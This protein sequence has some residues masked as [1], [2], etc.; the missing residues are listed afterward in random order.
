MKQL[1]NLLYRMLGIEKY[2]FLISRTYL[3][4]INLGFFKNRYAEL[5]Y[6]KKLIK[7]GDVCIDI[8][9][10]LGYYSVMM[11]KCCGE[12]GKLIAVEPVPLFASIWRRNMKR[13]IRNYQLE[14]CALGAKA[15]GIRMATPEVAGVLHHGMT[16]VLEDDKPEHKIFFDAEMKIPDVVFASLDK[17]DFVKTDVEGYEAIVFSNMTT[18]L[19]KFMPVIQTELSGNE[20]R[21]K[22]MHLL[23]SLGYAVYVLQSHSLVPATQ[24]QI[25]SHQSD[26]YFLPPGFKQ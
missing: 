14:V 16:Q 6:L 3:S 5:Y 10:N 25:H 13:S 11:S 17:L 24:V 19:K 21:N 4:L 18:T 26:F 1:R 22:V 12:Q 15:A 7:P 20:N 23:Q 2:L 8:G 9:A